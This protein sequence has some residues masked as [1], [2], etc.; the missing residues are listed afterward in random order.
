MELFRDFF[1][2]RNVLVANH[3]YSGNIQR[4]CGQQRQSTAAT[5][6]HPANSIPAA[7]ST[8]PA[9]SIPDATSNHP[10][11]RS[12]N[13]QQP[14]AAATNSSNQQQ[15]PTVAINS[16]NNHNQ[17]QQPASVLPA[18]P[19]RSTPASVSYHYG[20]QQRKSR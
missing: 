14:P 5:S 10:A 17:Q 3:Q 2:C 8:H 9:S 16:S 13:Q 18:A 11:T 15:Q 1:A 12:S 6:N 7:S 20:S 19:T 4:L